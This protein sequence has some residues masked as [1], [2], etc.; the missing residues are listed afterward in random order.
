MRRTEQ[1]AVAL[2]DALTRADPCL[3]HFVTV[4]EDPVRAVIRAR[5]TGGSGAWIASREVELPVR[6][7]DGLE[8]IAIRLSS[9]ICARAR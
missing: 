4:S 8:S 7:E 9:A 1:I 5:W 2:R 3:Q 6:P